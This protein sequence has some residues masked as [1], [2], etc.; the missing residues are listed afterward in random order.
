MAL[1]SSQEV[2]VYNLLHSVAV[3]SCHFCSASVAIR[4]GTVGIYLHK[5]VWVSE[6]RRGAVLRGVWAQRRC[7]EGEMQ[8]ISTQRIV[9]LSARL[10]KQAG[11]AAWRFSLIAKCLILTVYSYQPWHVQQC[12]AVDFHFAGVLLCLHI[13]VQLQKYGFSDQ[14]NPMRLILRWLM[15]WPF[16]I[17]LSIIHSESSINKQMKAFVSKLHYTWRHHLYH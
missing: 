6:E 3:F 13:T 7:S 8:H 14:Y 4:V 11:K 17:R 15:L 9:H 2:F 5:N 16:L 10:C 1:N 12:H